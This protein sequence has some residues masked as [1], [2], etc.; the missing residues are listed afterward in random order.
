MPTC[1]TRSLTV[2]SG[3]LGTRAARSRVATWRNRVKSASRQLNRRGYSMRV[4]L[5]QGYDRFDGDSRYRPQPEPDRPLQAPHF[6]EHR[7]QRR[8]ERDHTADPD[9]GPRPEGL[10]EPADQPAAD[11]V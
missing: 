9:A 11:R 4:T 3:Q 6:Q 5:P 1:S 8:T 7:D 10:G 2:H